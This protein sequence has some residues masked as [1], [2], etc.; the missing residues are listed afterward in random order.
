MLLLEGEG[1]TSSFAHGQALALIV[2]KSWTHLFLLG[3]ATP[4]THVILM[5]LI[6]PENHLGHQN[7]N[8]PQALLLK[9]PHIPPHSDWAVG[10]MDT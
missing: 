3:P 1:F 9:L 4:Q 5:G 8:L 2:F 7:G 10:Q 6:T